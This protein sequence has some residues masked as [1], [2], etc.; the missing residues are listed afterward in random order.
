MRGNIE[1]LNNIRLV[2]VLLVM[3]VIL[4]IYAVLL[5][6]K[7]KKQGK[8]AVLADLRETAYK[9]FLGAEEKYG[10]KTGPQKMAYTITQF[11]KLIAPDIIEQYIKPDTVEQFLQGLFDN[12]CKTLKDYLDDGQMNSSV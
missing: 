1:M 8:E 3:V 4:I 11:Y 9:L 5:Y 12:G 2:V 7:Y 6:R 10:S